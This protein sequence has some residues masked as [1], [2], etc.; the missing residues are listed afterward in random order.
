M[1]AKKLDSLS[2]LVH[3]IFENNINRLR[4]APNNVYRSLAVLGACAFVL[5]IILS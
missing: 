1:I 4:E 3:H 5:R 2:I